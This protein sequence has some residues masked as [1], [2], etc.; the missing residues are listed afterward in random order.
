MVNVYPNRRIASIPTIPFGPP[1]TLGATLLVNSTNAS[2][3]NSVMIA[4]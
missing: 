3:K 4:R 1:S 2:P